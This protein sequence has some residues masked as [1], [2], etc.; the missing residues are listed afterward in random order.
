MNRFNIDDKVTHKDHGPGCVIG[1]SWNAVRTNEELTLVERQ[2][3]VR[4]AHAA[5]YSPD[6]YTVRFGVLQG[7][8]GHI[9]SVTAAELSP[10]VE[11]AQQESV[12]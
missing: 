8:A 4:D 6:S 9:R 7:A 1:Q 11:G 12:S 3:L 10:F 5:G 2:Q